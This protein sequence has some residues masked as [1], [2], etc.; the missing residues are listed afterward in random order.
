MLRF[1]QH[2]W[3]M[4]AIAAGLI[5]AALFFVYRVVTNDPLAD[6]IIHTVDIGT[7]QEIIAVAGTV[8][9]ANLVNL[10]FPASGGI[11][12]AVYVEEGSGVQAG[13]I[14]AT[15]AND[16]LVSER[17]SALAAVRLAEA[18]LSELIA[19]PREE[20]R[21]LTSESVLIAEADLAR[22]KREQAE[23]IAAAERTLRSSGLTART[24]DPDD[25]AVAPTISGTYTCSEEGAYLVSVYRAG[26]VSGYAY[27]L[28]GLETARDSAST[29]QPAAL[30]SCGL[31]IQFDEGGKYQNTEWLVTIPNPLDP[32]YTT[33]KNNLIRVKDTAAIAIA[34]AEE[35]VAVARLEA[36]LTNAPPRSEAI[37]RAE[38]RVT[39]AR[40]Q[41]SQ[42]ETSLSDRSIVAPFAGTITT[43]DI[44][45]G[46]T[47]GTA[48]VITLLATD[49]F[50]VV[51]RIP[52]IDITKIAVGNSATLTF[53]ARVS[54]PQAAI[55]T[56]LSP[57]PTQI[58]GVAY[59]TAKLKLV[60]PPSWI[61]GGLNADVDIL[62]DEVTDVVRIPRRFLTETSTGFSVLTLATD[63]TISTSTVA[64]EFI[65]N[66]GYVA[67]SG[68]TVGTRIVAP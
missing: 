68:I 3:T 48:P 61:R 7:V 60:E 19:G 18:D 8:E 64:V 66:D 5:A 29:N 9:A 47:A 55:I 49:S 10:A 59:F 36:G 50:E 30:G 33:N 22:T 65:G 2:H 31:F 6:R 13:D 39:Q 46:E 42:I 57:L 21:A 41:L 32:L 62:V 4:V 26:S 37:T 16:S 28:S 17:T 12:A 35:A 1:V 51:A 25:E 67:I 40:A 15:L 52:E 24:N 38:A 43:V 56:Y 44:T 14:L 27:T 34:R 54:E 45:K 23:L 58:D 20:A 63:T 11:I 53:D